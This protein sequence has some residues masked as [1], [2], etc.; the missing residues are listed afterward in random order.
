MQSV[1]IPGKVMLSGEYAVLGG[2]EA[3]LLPVPRWLVL[4]RADAPPEEPYPPALQAALSIGIPA[5]AA[6]E[7]QAGVPHVAIDRAEFTTASASGGSV[8]L[9]LGMS[10]AEAVGVIALRYE[11]A[12]VAWLTRW[13]EVAELALAAH[14][15]AQDDI[16]SGAD[17]VAC[18]Y[19][20]PLRY[21]RDGEG[22][23]MRDIPAPPLSAQ[24]PLTLVWTG[25][26]A[27][28]RIAVR[29][30]NRWKDSTDPT[31]QEML[32]EC[33]DA[34]NNLANAWFTAPQAELNRLLDTYGG[35]MDQ[36]AAA[37]GLAYQLPVHSRLAAWARRHGGRAK[38][39]GAGGG[40][41]VLLVG[42]L[43]LSQLGEMQM[44]ELCYGE[45]WPA[46]GSPGRTG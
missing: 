21:R 37:A 16:G 23:I 20:R 28:T 12:G 40:D 42:E 43:P 32:A 22:F 34:A 4:E 38:P 33:R 3:V 45:L 44:I 7:E 30:F 15:L 6:H 29:H 9:G 14:T 2:A 41:M 1:R 10:A 46:I 39:T 27:D 31:A 36:I 13:R 11:C 17:V 24:V 35:I 26:P 25:H 8:K 5:I 19:G 18:A